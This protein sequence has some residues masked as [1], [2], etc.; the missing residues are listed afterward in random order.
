M[1]TVV[2]IEVLSRMILNR[3]CS[4][5]SFY[6]KGGRVPKAGP[7]PCE[8]PSHPRMQPGMSYVKMMRPAGFVFHPGFRRVSRAPGQAVFRKVFVFLGLRSGNLS[9]NFPGKS[10]LD[11]RDGGDYRVEQSR[12]PDKPV[13]MHSGVIRSS[14]SGLSGCPATCFRTRRFRGRDGFHGSGH[15]ASFDGC[16][17]RDL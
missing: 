2:F 14:V 10:E 7:E 3:W 4:K 6:R 13:Q 8:I 1:R 5:E 16:G 17:N 15:S 12:V 9:P 11:P